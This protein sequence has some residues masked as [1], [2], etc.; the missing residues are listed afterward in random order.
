[1]TV[2]SVYSPTGSGWF[3]LA[4]AAFVHPVVPFVQVLGAA[5]LGITAG[6]VRLITMVPERGL[7]VLGVVTDIGAVGVAVILY[8]L[9]G[10]LKG[11]W[12]GGVR[13]CAHT[14]GSIAQGA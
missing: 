6:C 5:S 12:S 10:G 9:P 13:W 8:R 1:M 7:A 11:I 2:V 4:V 14:V 3:V